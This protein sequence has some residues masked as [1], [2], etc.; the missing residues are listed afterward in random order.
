MK[1]MLLNPGKT[2]AV[3]FG[4]RAQREK[5]QESVSIIPFGETVKLLGVT[6]DCTTTLDRHV[7]EVVCRCS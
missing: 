7:A 6:L 1:G 5:R 2:E 3:V 4:T